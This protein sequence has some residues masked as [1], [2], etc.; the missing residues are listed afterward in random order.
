MVRDFIAY[1][2]TLKYTRV[3]DLLTYDLRCGSTRPVNRRTNLRSA[4]FRLI[5]WGFPIL[6]EALSFH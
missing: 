1:L 2:F 4:R 6:M 3:Y 5:G